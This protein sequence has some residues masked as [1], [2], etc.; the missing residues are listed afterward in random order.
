M[1]I[2]QSAAMQ[3]FL[4]NAIPRFAVSPSSSAAPT[5][6][7]VEEW[8]LVEDPLESMHEI[9]QRLFEE[10]TRHGRRVAGKRK[11]AIKGWG[12]LAD[13]THTYYGKECCAVT[14]REMTIRKLRIHSTLQDP[15]LSADVMLCPK[16]SGKVSAEHTCQTCNLRPKRNDYLACLGCLSVFK[17]EPKYVD[18]MP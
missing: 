1:P 14:V 13:G 4:K 15:E 18:A 17:L 3:H 16:C 7:L 2:L 12:E 9:A 8:V 11:R 5:Q 10:P 6:Q